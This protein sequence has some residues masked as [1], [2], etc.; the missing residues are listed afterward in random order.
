MFFCGSWHLWNTSSSATASNED[1]AF[2]YGAGRDPGSSGLFRIG[3]EVTFVVRVSSGVRAP[4]DP[5]L[6]AKR[7]RTGARCGQGREKG[8]HRE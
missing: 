1:K 6:C 5:K 3:S 7:A 2:G 8:D 4:I